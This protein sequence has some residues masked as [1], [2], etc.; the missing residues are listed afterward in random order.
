MTI[1]QSSCTYLHFYQKITWLHTRVYMASLKCN[2]S[3]SDYRV[4]CG[5]PAGISQI[6]NEAEQC[7][8]DTEQSDRNFY[9][10]PGSCPFLKLGYLSFW[11]GVLYTSSGSDGKE[12]A[13]NA[14]DLG[15]IPGLGRSPGGGHGN[16]LQYSCLENPHGQKG[17]MGCSPWGCRELDTT[18]QLSTRA[19]TH[20]PP[21]KYKPFTWIFHFEHAF[22]L[23]M[24]YFGEWKFLILMWYYQYF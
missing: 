16:P 24:I 15:L 6:I 12:S 14:G 11:F 10:V 13:C 5:I 22:T 20:T 1:F 23:L 19:R 2:Y 18:E 9:E 8:M 7:F 17:L 21:S 4:C 3:Y